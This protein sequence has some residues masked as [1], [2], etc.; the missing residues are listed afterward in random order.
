[1][2]TNTISAF[3]EATAPDK[4]LL[5]ST[6]HFSTV[7][8]EFLPEGV[9]LPASF[10]RTFDWLEGR[11]CYHVL[12]DGEHP[13]DY[14]LS[15]YPLNDQSAAENA[16]MVAFHPEYPRF[17]RDWS[18]PDPAIDERIITLGTISSDGGRIVL[19]IDDNGK[20][21]F[22]HLGTQTL[23]VISDNPL[24]TLQFLAMGYREPGQLRTM[25]ST[26]L[27]E[28]LEHHNVVD[29]GGVDA[30]FVDVAPTVPPS[31]LQAFLK[32]EFKVSLPETARDLGIKDFVAYGDPNTTDPFARW[33]NSL[34]E[35]SEKPTVVA[36]QPTLASLPHFNE[37][38]A[39][40]HSDA[41][42]PPPLTSGIFSKVKNWFGR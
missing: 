17:T 32:R 9:S 14:L 29:T 35:T 11:G 19:W 4:D 16:S 24:I 36:P 3:L 15:I 1:M 38:D 33:I 20:N 10:V 42:D 2:R 5:I 25:A 26:P 31:D 13:E 27:K 34:S 41:P 28:A 30:P 6:N 37:I 39:Q 18:Q 12:G 23:G 40:T 21:W 8:R 22:A 7:M